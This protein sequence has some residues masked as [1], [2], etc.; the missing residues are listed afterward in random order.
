MKK[1]IGI[2]MAVLTATTAWAAGNAQLSWDSSAT[3][4]TNYY[5]NMDGT[6]TLVLDIPSDVRS[7]MVYDDGGKNGNHKDRAWSV[8]QMNAPDGYI[9]HLQGRLWTD[10]ES[11]FNV[12]DGRYGDTE[13]ISGL[14][15]YHS[16]EET[17]IPSVISSGKTM[18]LKF[19]AYYDAEAFEGL[20]LV[21]TVV[22]PDEK[23]NISRSGSSPYGNF[24]WDKSTASADELVTM[25]AQPAEGYVLK[26]LRVQ[27]NKTNLYLNVDWDGPFFNTA[28]F[29]MHPNDVTIYP[30]FSNDLTGLYVNLPTTGN[31]HVYIP[32]GARQVKVY[33]D[34]GEDR[35][36]TGKGDGS[37]TLT[38]P[39]GYILKVSGYVYSAQDNDLN[40]YDGADTSCKWIARE[41]CRRENYT[42]RPSTVSSKII[43][44]GRDI[45][46]QFVVA[47]L[48]GYEGINL[49]VELIPTITL[50]PGMHAEIGVKD[51]K[52]YAFEGDNIEFYAYSDYGYTTGIA[53]YKDDKGDHNLEA[54]YGNTYTFQMPATP[55]T[56]YA[57]CVPDPKHFSYS[58]SEY[59][60]SSEAGWDVFCD[61][62]EENEKGYFDGKTVKLGRYKISIKRMAGSSHHDFTG[63]FDGDGGK[64]DF[65]YTATEAY[66]APFRYMEGGTIKNLTVTG[67]INT[68]AKYAAGFI[69]TQYG[70]TTIENCRSSII[71]NSSVNGDGTHGGFV[72]VTNSGS[73]Q[74]LT[75]EGCIF[76]GQLLGA[77]TDRCGGFVGWVGHTVD[78]RYSI[79][80]PS[81]ITVSDTESASFARY[82][83]GKV[84]THYTYSVTPLGE[85]QCDELFIT[86]AFP[87]HGAAGKN[88]LHTEIESYENGFKWNGK[89]YSD[90][91]GLSLDYGKIAGIGKCVGTFY[92]GTAHL[93]LPAGAQAYTVAEGENG[94]EF[95]RIGAEGNVIPKGTPVVVISAHD[96]I[97]L[98][99]LDEANVTVGPNDLQASDTD[100]DNSGHDKY[101]LTTYSSNYG[102]YKYYG[103]TIPAGKAYIPAK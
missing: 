87:N 48:D 59:T 77:E 42:Y 44:S 81:K 26:N 23:H 80:N 51:D 50:A 64:L 41:F 1:I 47:T 82:K 72:G 12:Y 54:T 103:N 60:I 55:V 10:T 20:E 74:S 33:D 95:Y 84:N 31:K 85:K 75:I 45:T 88:Y 73:D 39:E 25:T 3:C 40:V 4:G 17:I 49:T 14:Q 71:I 2:L 36:P 89:C 83:N 7:F 68:S 9:L 24:L 16:G 18:S 8:L 21:V 13:L 34:G 93:R 66:A 69:A 53:G 97:A 94:L 91:L 5:I 11:Y 99:R 70:A 101:I 78:I 63:T 15:S 90:K 62:L 102:F 28:S 32:K 30:E 58:N 98:T 92:C 52:T 19:E 43:S 57:T 35:S 38:A 100:V 67:T 22:K 56:L 29:R 86:S 61:L 27:D 79:F 65:N 6:G 37:V 46:I 76:D 96:I